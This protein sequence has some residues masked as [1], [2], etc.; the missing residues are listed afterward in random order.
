MGDNTLYSLV[1]RIGRSIRPGQ[2]TGSIE[3]I[4]PFVLHCAH[5][6][7]LYRNDHKNIQIVFSTI[8][9]LVPFHGVLQ[10]H[11]CVVDL[12]DV[13]RLCKDP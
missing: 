3:N 8:H 5:V 2:Y 4:E 7:T 13:V 12:V 6:E 11:H 10:R 9:C 1:S